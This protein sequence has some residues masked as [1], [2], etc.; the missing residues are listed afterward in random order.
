MSATIDPAPVCAF[1]ATVPSI[2]VPGRAHPVEID[3]APAQPLAQAVRELC[4]VDARP[5]AVLPARR[6][7]RF[8]RARDEIARAGA[9]DSRC[10][11]CTDRST[12][13]EQ[14]ARSRRR[15]RAG[16]V[17]ARDEHRRDVA[18]RA[19]R[20][21]GDRHG[22]HKV[23]RY[24]AG[25]RHRYAGH[26]A[27][28]ADSA[29][30]RAGRAARL[31][32]GRV[33][34]LW[35]R[36]A[37]GCGRSASP[38][39]RASISP[40][41]LLDVL[42]W[43]GDRGRL[44]MVRGAARRAARRGAWSC[45]SASARSPAA[46][47]TPL[48]RQLQRCRCIR[49]SPASCSRRTAPT[50]PP[51]RARCSPSAT[52]AAAARGDDLRSARGDRSLARRAAARA[53]GRARDS[54][55]RRLACSAATRARTSTSSSCGARSSRLPGSCGAAPRAGWRRV[56][57][58]RRAPARR[59]RAESGVHEG[60]LA[61]RARRPGGAAADVGGAVPEARVRIASRV[62]PEWLTPTSV[63][64][65]HRFDAATGRVRAVRRE[66]YD[67]LVL[68]R[69]AAEARRRRA[70]APAGRGVAASAGR[71]D[72][73][74]GCSR[75]LRF[76]GARRPTRG[77]LV[78]CRRAG[79][80]ACARRR[81]SRA[82]SSTRRCARAR[83]RWRRTT[84]RVPSGRDAC[85]RYQED[86]SVSAAVKLQELF[87]LAETPR[88][89]ARREPVLL[90]TARAERPAG[91]DDARSAELLDSHLP[92]GAQG[93]ARPLSEASLARRSLDRA[94]PPRATDRQE[95]RER[96]ADVL[97]TQP[98]P[99]QAEEQR[100]GFWSVAALCTSEPRNP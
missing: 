6:R 95:A 25:S 73:D 89:G 93:A 7:A 97:R 51:R 60:E 87:G 21:H 69:A 32:P 42:A 64:R 94:R 61:R 52:A 1:L 71:A 48:G 36:R 91:A 26:R 11:R 30:Q 74:P 80:R 14:D 72:D 77:A 55:T 45:S 2:D 44:R 63:E 62:E 53:T 81:R 10:C 8:A 67:A 96:C 84:L 18:H 38:T 70:G 83:S 66:L 56:C 92:R 98:A 58:W 54:R 47:L 15:R 59:S 90:A 23:A 19:G 3:Y 29:D 100:D 79:R 65:V 46:A 33:R 82:R 49:G 12:A 50:R 27:H 75:R 9:G 17:D 43:G 78:A 16:R 99:A 13:D 86:G 28:L 34:R 85:A 4:G 35:D 22:L 88:I 20:R 24:D 37:I 41:P 57:C 40:A 39:S 76:A 31:G 5:G 68:S